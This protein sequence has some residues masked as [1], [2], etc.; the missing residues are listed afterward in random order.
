MPFFC[1]IITQ[2][3]QIRKKLKAHRNKTRK[4]PRDTKLLA[5]MNGLT[6]AAFAEAIRVNP[7]DKS[8][9]VTGQKLSQFL[10]CL[11]DGKKLRR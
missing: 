7:K 8:L 2:I 11:W 6:L 10:I 1:L 3:K 4:I 9:Q 5:G